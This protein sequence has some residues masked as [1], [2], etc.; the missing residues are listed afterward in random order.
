MKCLN[1]M[2]LK[3]L[4][5]MSKMLKGHGFWIIATSNMGSFERL[6]NRELIPVATEQFKGTLGTKQSHITLGKLLSFSL[7]PLPQEND[8]NCP[9][10]MVI[11]G[12][13]KCVHLC[14]LVCALENEASFS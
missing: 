9:G 13:E 4:V 5:T 11:S 12:V 7:P 2:K 14:L 6:R 8:I 1:F 10:G 3:H